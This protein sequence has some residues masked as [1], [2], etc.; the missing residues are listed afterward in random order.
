MVETAFVLTCTAEVRQAPALTSTLLRTVQQG[1]IVKQ[2]GRS[3]TIGG[4]ERIPV[5]PRGWLN[6]DVLE[7]VNGDAPTGEKPMAPSHSSG[8]VA[9]G[10]T[11]KVSKATPPGLEASSSA[12]GAAAGYPAQ[13]SKSKVEVEEPCLNPPPGFEDYETSEKKEETHTPAGGER[14]SQTYYSKSASYEKEA[15][16]QQQWREQGQGQSDYNNGSSWNDNKWDSSKKNDDWWSS[17]W[18]TNTKDSSSGGG[19]ADSAWK[20]WKPDESNNYQKEW[21]S[22]WSS[23]KWTTKEEETGK[24]Q[25]KKPGKSNVNDALRYDPEDQESMQQAVKFFLEESVPVD[26][27][28]KKYLLSQPLGVQAT[29]A[30]MGLISTNA[31]NPTAVLISR[32]RKLLDQPAGKGGAPI[33]AGKPT[34]PQPKMVEF[35]GYGSLEAAAAEE[36][37]E[38]SAE[39][40]HAEASSAEASFEEASTFED[41]VRQYFAKVDAEIASTAPEEKAARI[42]GVLAKISK[43]ILAKDI[44]PSLFGSFATPFRSKQSDYDVSLKAPVQDQEQATAFLASVADRL[45]EAGFTHITR[46][47]GATNPIIKCTDVASEL[48]IDICA[49]NMLAERNT[50]LLNA[51]CKCD[52]RLV[53]L[54]RFIKVWTKSRDLVGSADGLL[55]SYAYILLVLHYALGLSPPLVP[56]LQAV[57]FQ[58]VPVWDTK[59]GC[60]DCWETGFLQDVSKYAGASQNSAGLHELLL[61]FFDYFCYFVWEEH[62]VCPRLQQPGVAID[63]FSLATHTTWEQWYIEDPFDLKH[64]LAAKCSDA[65]RARLKREMAFAAEVLRS[66]R[67]RLRDM[68]IRSEPERYYLRCRVAGW[69]PPEELLAYFKKVSKIHY[70]QHGGLSYPAY[71]E[72]ATADTCREAHSANELKIAGAE[73]QL[74]KT[75][76]QSVMDAIMS[77]GVTY[78]ELENGLEAEAVSPQVLPKLSF[79]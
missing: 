8:W 74:T 36:S 13:W 51:Y 52:E 1:S 47:F 64:N 33:G 41:E 44:Q 4:V 31:R 75:T 71:L 28:A 43:E 2:A 45:P 25:Q 62:A 38:A 60:D 40:S 21:D 6:R 18:K 61:G 42:C 50:A 46:V 9:D 77:S 37:T 7:P 54:G 55:N 63:K 14:A 58:S 27:K 72:F 30:S 35:R 15:S 56:N 11:P 24:T 79:Q 70:A 48:E 22:S 10:E 68:C 16:S 3:I 73:L 29:V 39:V 17:D 12:A 49:N 76:R 67:P 34:Q 26:E 65:G 23:S 78:V 20:N 66:E 69:L 19:G 5:L 59:W 53:Q 32:I 57:Q